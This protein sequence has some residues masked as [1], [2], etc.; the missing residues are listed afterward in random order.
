M[1]AQRIEGKIVAEK[2]KLEVAQGVAALKLRGITPGLTVIIVGADPASQV[3][4]RN[5][6]AACEKVGIRSSHIELPAETTQTE[7]LSHI[8]RL[9]ADPYRST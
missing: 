8:A 5:K 3:Y 2:V 6:V 7:L 1:S 4:V 9:N